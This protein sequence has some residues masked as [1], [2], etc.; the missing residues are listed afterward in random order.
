MKIL[1]YKKNSNGKYT[2]FLDDGKSL[3]LYEDVILLYNLLLKKEI[4]SEDIE[5]ICNTNFEYDV[6]YVALK[7]ITSRFKSVYELRAFLRKKEYPEELIDN[8]ILKLTSQGYLNDRLFTKSYIN[9]Q[10]S[11]TSNGPYRIIRELENKKIDSEIINDEIVVFTEDIQEEKI[12]KIIEKLLKTNHTRGGLVL[13]QKI[14]DDL[15]N[16]GYLYEVISR[17]VDNYDFSCD[18]KIAKKEYDKLY[19][20]YSTKYEGYQLDKIIKEK[21]YSKGLVYEEE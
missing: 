10:I 19:K 4:N 17:V 21:L 3:V 13:K 1:K 16:K 15:K 14:V 18:K 8:A 20:K 6:Y 12:S 2:I 11:T 7:S 5:E 9:T